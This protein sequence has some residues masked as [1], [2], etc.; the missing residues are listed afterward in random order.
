MGRT[1]VTPSEQ[2]LTILERVVQT[3]NTERLMLLA[4]SGTH[5][6]NPYHNTLHELQNTYYSF[7]CFVNES[8][9]KDSGPTVSDL[10][11]G[12]LFHDHNH[13]GGILRDNQNVER[14][15]EFVGREL[16]LKEPVLRIIAVTEFSD[17][18]FPIEPTNLAERCI[19]DADLM[20]IYSQEGFR[21]MLGL[22]EE[23]SGKPLRKFTEAEVNSALK[24]TAEF[25]TA[26]QM[27]T[28]HGKRMRDEHL[29]GQLRKFYD[30]VQRQWQYET[31]TKWR[32]EGED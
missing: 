25:L 12:S 3:I 16:N 8:G 14:A 2:A 9:G 6:L 30:Y 32:R 15:M 31:D 24:R 10:V 7:S 11:L 1:E 23:M 21:L 22:F 17:N 5:N 18:K 28:D 13:S 19:R 27:F 26:Q 20:T 4:N 29:F